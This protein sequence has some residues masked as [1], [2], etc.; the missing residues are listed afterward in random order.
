MMP[1]LAHHLKALQVLYFQHHQN[2]EDPGLHWMMWF[3]Q[4]TLLR[5][6]NLLMLI[7]VMWLMPPEVSLMCSIRVYEKSRFVSQD[8]VRYNMYC[9]LLSLKEKVRSWRDSPGK[10]TVHDKSEEKATP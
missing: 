4:L 6:L 1:L 2:P 9:I 8:N 5:L 10:Q 7:Q 3:R